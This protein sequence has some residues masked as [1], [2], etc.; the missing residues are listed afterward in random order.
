MS[1]VPKRKADD[2]LSLIRN[3]N[4]FKEA[5]CWPIEGPLKVQDR[6][7]DDFTCNCSVL[8]DYP[9]TRTVDY[10]IDYVLHLIEQNGLDKARELLNDSDRFPDIIEKLVW[11]HHRAYSRTTRD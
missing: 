7:I 3:R 11:R 2:I 6:V 4:K 9:I 10:T 1:R 5:G 8:Q